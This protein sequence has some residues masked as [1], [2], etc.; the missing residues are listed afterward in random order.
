MGYKMKGFGGFGNSPAKQE[1]PIDKENVKLQKGEMEGTWVY[2]GKDKSE[3]MIDLEDRIEFLSSD[4]RGGSDRPGQNVADM[5]K[6]KKKL[7]QELAILRK[8]KHK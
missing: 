5:K 2:P 6:S 1:G 7:Q 8:S 3:R 4:I